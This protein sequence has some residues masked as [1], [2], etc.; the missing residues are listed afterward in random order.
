MSGFGK[1][2]PEC[3]MLRQCQETR[4]NNDS[5]WDSS[6]LKT[7]P[8]VKDRPEV[9]SSAEELQPQIVQ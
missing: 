8:M 2:W 6:S 1:F 9:I 5:P 3:L 7:G 4:S